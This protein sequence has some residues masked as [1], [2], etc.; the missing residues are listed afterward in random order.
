MADSYRDSAY[1]TIDTDVMKL[2]PANMLTLSDNDDL[3]PET[4]DVPR[5][6]VDTASARAL[7]SP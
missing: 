7:P 1:F 3:V 6:D 5:T 2:L 4:E